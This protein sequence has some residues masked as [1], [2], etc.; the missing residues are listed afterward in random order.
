MDYAIF[1]NIL[2][3]IEITV[4]TLTSALEVSENRIEL[5]NEL[6]AVTIPSIT[7][8]SELV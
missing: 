8:L 7:F 4:E 5:I 1:P 6:W 2:S 3:N